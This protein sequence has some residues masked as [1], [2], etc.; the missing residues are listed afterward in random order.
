MLV[1]GDGE[2]LSLKEAEGS[3]EEFSGEVEGSVCCGGGESE[4]VASIKK[5]NYRSVKDGISKQKKNKGGGHHTIQQKLKKTNKVWLGKQ[6]V[7]FVGK[8]DS[9]YPKDFDRSF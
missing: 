7:V 3:R 9:V 4:G 5:H 8:E 1:S 6:R 2:G